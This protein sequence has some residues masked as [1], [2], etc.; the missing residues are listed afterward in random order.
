MLKRIFD[1]FFS[2]IG[3]L[4]IGWL[5]VLFWIVT[6]IDTRSNGFFFQK[7]IGQLGRLFTI[8]KLKTMHPVTGRISRIGKFFRSSKLDELPQFWNVLVGKM[9]MVGPRPDIPGYYDTLEGEQKKILELK[10]GLVSLAAIKYSNEEALLA[11]QNNPLEYNDKLIFP[12]K[13]KMNLEYYYNNSIF[14]DILIILK[15]I[16]R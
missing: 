10:P 9:S 11:N 6:S 13:V 4:L 16:F 15:T 3:I 7:R 5:I 12:D 2:L 1:L 8:Y 14:R